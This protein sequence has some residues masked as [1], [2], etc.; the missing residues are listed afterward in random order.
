MRSASRTRLVRMLDVKLPADH[1]P[2]PDVDHE[3]QEDDA[4]P[5]TQVGEVRDPEFI[6]PR[7]LEAPLDEIRQRRVRSGWVV[8]HCL[9]RPFAP[10]IPS[11]ILVSRS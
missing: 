10:R 5:A 4:M 9:V 7:R 3:A 1:A 6:R 11:F 2:A 8:R